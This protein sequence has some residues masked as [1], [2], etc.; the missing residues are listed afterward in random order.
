MQKRAMLKGQVE[1]INLHVY[2]STVDHLQNPF[3]I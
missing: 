1:Q 2:Q 3:K